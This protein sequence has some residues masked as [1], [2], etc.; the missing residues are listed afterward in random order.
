MW[1]MDTLKAAVKNHQAAKQSKTK[2]AFLKK[3]TAVIA[4]LFLSAT[5]FAQSECNA[6]VRE[7]V[8]PKLTPYVHNGLLNTTT[9]KPGETAELDILF[10]NGHDYRLMVWGEGSEEQLKFRIKDKTN[11]VLFDSRTQEGNANHI[12]FHAKTTERLNIEVLSPGTEGG[13]EAGCVSVTVGLKEAAMKKPAPGVAV[14][15]ER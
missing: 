13:T 10:V 1:G 6:I 8:L 14:T 4:L 3:L 2:K 11:K 5:T 7:Q 15:N 9:L 12:D